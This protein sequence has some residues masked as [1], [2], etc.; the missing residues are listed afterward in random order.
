MV[1]DSVRAS[2]VN[3]PPEAFTSIAII[4]MTLSGSCR[5]GHVRDV[6]PTLGADFPPD[7]DDFEETHL[8]RVAPPDVVYLRP[9]SSLIKDTPGEGVA[10]PV[11]APWRM[12]ILR[13]AR[14][15]YRRWGHASRVMTISI[16]SV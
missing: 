13:P 5:G 1:L 14:T 6:P 11:T 15:H 12:W 2:D 9:I 16:V 8:A 3:L 4:Q 10:K 7:V